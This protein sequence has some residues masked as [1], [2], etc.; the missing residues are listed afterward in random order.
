MITET[1]NQV[2]EM[3]ESLGNLE[4]PEKTIL[5]KRSTF[6]DGEWI[7]EKT[8]VRFLNLPTEYNKVLLVGVSQSGDGVICAYKRQNFRPFEDD[9]SVYKYAEVPDIFTGKVGQDFFMEEK[10]LEDSSFDMFKEKAEYEAQIEA[11]K[12]EYAEKIEEA[13]LNEKKK[14]GDAVLGLMIIIGVL[15]SFIASLASAIH[16]PTFLNILSSSLF[17]V[18]LILFIKISVTWKITSK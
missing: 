3:I 11:E 5:S 18:A 10:P 15:L 8:N 12:A 1:T 7:E 9:S 16:A 17:G 2:Q 13:K 6:E 14:D 4:M